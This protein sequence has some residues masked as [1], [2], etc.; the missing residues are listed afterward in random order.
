[1]KLYISFISQAGVSLK[2]LITEYVGSSKGL[3]KC[4][5]LDM[6][7][8]GKQDTCY[9]MGFSSLQST[10]LRSVNDMC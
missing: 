6:D 5:I 9:Q 10:M 4:R 3:V 2:V 8:T 1:M 7:Q